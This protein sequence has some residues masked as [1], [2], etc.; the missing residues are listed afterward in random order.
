MLEPYVFYMPPFESR[1]PDN[2]V[3]AVP[4]S[5]PTTD[6]L[7]FG[8]DFG[9]DSPAVPVIA[10]A[11]KKWFARSGDSDRL[12]IWFTTED[13]LIEG[14]NVDIVPVIDAGSFVIIVV[15]E[16]TNVCLRF[17]SYLL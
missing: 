13:S 5:Q 7:E 10:K 2:Y 1:G 17:V 8:N 9:Q 16:R 3:T 14:A 15:A 6:Y 4:L 12:R 11:M